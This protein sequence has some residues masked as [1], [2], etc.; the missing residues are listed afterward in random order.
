MHQVC[1]FRQV[2]IL[3]PTDLCNLHT[4]EVRLPTQRE[5]LSA[6]SR[7]DERGI[8]LLFSEYFVSLCKVAYHIV[9]D[10]DIAKDIVQDVFVRLWA[11][12]HKLNIT[13]SLAAYL[14]KSVVN[15][16][17]D[18]QRKALRVRKISLDDYTDEPTAPASQAPDTDLQAADTNKKI[19]QALAALPPR[20]RLVFS[21]SRY[22]QLTYA[23]IAKSLDISTKTVEN[24]MTKALK[25]LR[26]HLGQYLAL[27]LILLAPLGWLLS[28]FFKST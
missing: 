16:S 28:L 2:C 8:D 21:M 12:R 24:Q 19:E 11:H 13:G 6:I 9:H 20:C 25:I 4:F 17:I 5:I 26:Q 14:R 18:H 3:R 15:A 1:F 23:E 10:P 27:L 7:G 22:E